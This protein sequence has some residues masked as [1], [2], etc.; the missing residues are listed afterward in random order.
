MR[1]VLGCGFV[2]APLVSR[3]LALA[4]APTED[5]AESAAVPGGIPLTG[6]PSFASLRTITRSGQI[7]AFEDAAHLE[8]ASGEQRAS[9]EAEISRQDSA[10]KIDR[11]A[12]DLQVATQDQWTRAL[13]GVSQLVCAYAAGRG[14]DRRTI[15]VDGGTKIARAAV[16]AGVEHV[17]Y[18]SST[19]ALPER[20]GLLDED[21]PE[22][23]RGERGE[24]QREAEDIFLATLGS[25]KVSCTVLRFA[26][27]YGPGRPLASLYLRDPGAVVPGDAWTHTNLVHRDDAVEAILRALARV[28]RYHGILHISDGEHMPRRSMIERVAAAKGMAAPSFE[29][30]ADCSRAPSGKQVDHR[31]SVQVLGMRYR[32]RDIGAA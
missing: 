7:R 22:R 1:C 9:S 13:S 19:S 28:P 30:P 27:L 14:Q 5:R 12:L 3:L 26:G 24:V 31:R 2:G 15:Y 23:P 17:V 25:A 20:D 10:S 6:A 16:A 18:C 21:A 8:G 11:L 32:S 29:L 4:V